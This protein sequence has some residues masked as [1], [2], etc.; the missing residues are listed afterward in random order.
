MQQALA[1][2]ASYW[3]G[4]L[5]EMVRSRQSTGVCCARPLLKRNEFGLN[6]PSRFSSLFEHDLFGKPLHTFP[7]R[8]LE[9]AHAVGITARA[10]LK[11]TRKPIKLRGFGEGRAGFPDRPFWPPTTKPDQDMPLTMAQGMKRLG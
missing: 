10:A 4:L 9:G 7:D 6:R 11:A 8:A 1:E 5:G 3:P 2:G